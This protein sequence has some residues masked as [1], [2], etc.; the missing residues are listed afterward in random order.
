MTVSAGPTTLR[1]ASSRNR[2][3]TPPTAMSRATEVPY[4][5]M[6]PS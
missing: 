3:R 1:A 5:A 4:R 6:M 2:T